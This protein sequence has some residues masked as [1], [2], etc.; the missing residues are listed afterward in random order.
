MYSAH[1]T[2]MK[3]VN[4]AL[5]HDSAVLVAAEHRFC[6]TALNK[7]FHVLRQEA[8]VQLNQGEHFHEKTRSSHVPFN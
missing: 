8:I 2:Y 3:H 7:P 1:Q 4:C 5:S 6:D